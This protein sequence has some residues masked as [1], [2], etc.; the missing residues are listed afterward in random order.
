MIPDTTGM[1]AG[2]VSPNIGAG[3]GAGGLDANTAMTAILFGQSLLNYGQDTSRPIDFAG[4]ATSY[5]GNINKA[6][7]MEQLLGKKASTQQNSQLLELFKQALDP[8]NTTSVKLDGKGMTTLYDPKTTPML[9][10]LLSGDEPF[11]GVVNPPSAPTPTPASTPTSPGG[12]PAV[13]SP[14]S[15]KQTGSALDSISPGDLVGLTT[16]DITDL[17]GARHAQDQLQGQ[18]YRDIVDAMYKGESLLESRR[19]YRKTAEHT[20][21]Q[22]LESK[23]RIEKENM[24]DKPFTINALGK[25]KGT[26]LR[27]WNALPKDEQDYQLFLFGEKQTLGTGPKLSRQEYADLKPTEKDKFFNRFMKDPKFKEATLE[28][29]KANA[30]HI[31]LSTK[32]AEKEALTQVDRQ[33]IV[34]K[35]GFSQSIE[36]KLSKTLRMAWDFPEGTAALVKEHGITEAQAAKALQRSLVRKEMDAQIKQAYPTA[37]WVKGEGWKVGNKLI[38]RDP[39]VK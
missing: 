25:E 28:Y 23:H 32:V 3:A 9:S 27:E 21:Q 6:K 29:A 11:E 13:S 24:L 36:E 20:E 17:L 1:F 26:T 18:T 30:V 19:A 37:T 38:V 39:Y 33:N 31:D 5:M 10:S 16:K 35:P 22:I 14:F 4:P 34:Q 12:G 7:L 15:V 8:N 2:G